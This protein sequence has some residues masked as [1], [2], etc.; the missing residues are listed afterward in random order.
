MDNEFNAREIAVQL[1]E[2]NQLIDNKLLELEKNVHKSIVAIIISD[3]CVNKCKYCKFFGT[4]IGQCR[5]VCE[6]QK[7]IL[8]HH[9]LCN[10]S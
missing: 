7:I 5:I 2:I 9:L 6:I 4:D 3:I 1:K 8:M 10:C